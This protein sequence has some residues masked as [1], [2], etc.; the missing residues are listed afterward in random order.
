M[1]WIELE[2]EGGR[3]RLSFRNQDALFSGLCT[4]YIH[5]RRIGIRI[6]IGI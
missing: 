4:Y 6:R 2:V 5:G 3:G 1:E